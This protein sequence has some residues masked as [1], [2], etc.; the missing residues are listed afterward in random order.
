MSP[1][2]GLLFRLTDHFS[3]RG[4][5]YQGFRAP[6]L[7]ELYRPFFLGGVLTN[8]NANLGPE[9]LAGVE[10]GFN[11]SPGR[12]F[13]W[14]ATGF[15]NRVKDPISN[16]TLSA[17]PALILRQRQN[18]GR[19]RVRGIDAEIEYRINTQWGIRSRYLFD[20]ATVR[21]FSANPEIEGKFI[22]Q[23][24]K[25]R[26]SLGLDYS[27]RKWFNVSLYGRFESLRFDDDINRFT[28]GSFF[29]AG[30]AASRP[31]R[32]P[33]EVFVSVE[34]LFNR[35]YPVRATPVAL[36]GTPIIVSAGVRFH[37]SPF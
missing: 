25:H 16:V 34:N 11:H 20:E 1:R 22:P 24:P 6:T 37:L 32:G 35:R 2:A 29:V 19:L 12:G 28:L 4:A 21:D 31:L 13:F 30:L 17:T 3:L 8:A 9:R 14:R 33:W 26:A 10:V 5:F 36:L 18:L 23:V 7:N 27:N 15:W